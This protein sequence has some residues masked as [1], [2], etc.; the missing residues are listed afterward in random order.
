MRYS[1]LTQAAL[2]LVRSAIDRVW[3]EQVADA[4]DSKPPSWLGLDELTE[5]GSLE[6]PGGVQSP[7]SERALSKIILPGTLVGLLATFEPCF[8]APRYRTPQWLV[9]PDHEQ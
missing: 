4:W 5:Q 1:P 8:H 2:N 6:D 9:A 3:P 7:G